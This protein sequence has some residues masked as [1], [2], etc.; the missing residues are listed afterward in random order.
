[1]AQIFH[2]S[3]NTISKVSLVCAVLGAGGLLAFAYA[4]AGEREEALRII[5]GILQDAKISPS[6]AY[7]TAL[8]YTKLGMN[9]DAIHWV[10][11]A[12][13]AGMGLMLIIGVEPTFAPLRSDPRF[14]VLLRKLGFPD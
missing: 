13:A 6:V 10:E 14:Q 1:M 4:I 9:E 5:D 7:W 8:T 2:R 3:T 12:H 11:H